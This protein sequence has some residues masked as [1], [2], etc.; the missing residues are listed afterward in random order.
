[1]HMRLKIMEKLS[2][3]LVNHIAFLD[4]NESDDLKKRLLFKRLAD[5]IEKDCK[6]YS[7]FYLEDK[8]FK[9]RLLS[10]DSMRKIFKTMF[11]YDRIRKITRNLFSNS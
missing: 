7:P 9:L 4:G 11:S 1:M 2:D 3:K 10:F 6:V 5:F 8:K